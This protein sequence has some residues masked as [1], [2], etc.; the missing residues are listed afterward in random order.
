MVTVVAVVRDPPAEE[1]RPHQGV[2]DLY[3]R[4]EAAPRM[5]TSRT[6]PITSLTVL[7]SENAL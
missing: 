5:F 2:G 1:R 4:S 3:T 7:L 6:K